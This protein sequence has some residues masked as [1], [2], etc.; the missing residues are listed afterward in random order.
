MFLAGVPETFIAAHGRWRSLEYRKYLD[1]IDDTQWR[2]T[3]L[4]AARTRSGL[5]PAAK[6][7]QL[8]QLPGTRPSVGRR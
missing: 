5:L 8:I 3:Q 1:F 2:P 4:L 6:A 7:A